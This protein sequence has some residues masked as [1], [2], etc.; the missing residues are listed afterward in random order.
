MATGEALKKG[1]EGTTANAIYTRNPIRVDSVADI[2][3][4]LY[5]L[6]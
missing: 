6:N 1:R 3:M 2:Y 5:R 4:S